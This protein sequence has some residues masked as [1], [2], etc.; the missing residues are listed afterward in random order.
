MLSK[1]LVRGTQM[2]MHINRN[3]PPVG[4]P[5]LILISDCWVEGTR[6]VWATKSDM[7]FD[8]VTNKGQVR[9]VPRSNMQWS[10]P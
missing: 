7:S 1:E 3:L 8:I 2:Q 9:N 5:I 10:Y 6:E 4:I